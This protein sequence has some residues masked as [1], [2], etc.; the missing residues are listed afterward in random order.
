MT[1]RDFI[2]KWCVYALALLPVW[3]LDAYVLSR[4]PLFGVKPMLLPL[5]AV[6]AAVLEGPASGGA[7]ALGVGFLCYAM[8]SGGPAMLLGL[9]LIGVASGFAA[10]YLLRQNLLGCF[11]CS[12]GSLL[13][14]DACRIVWRLLSGTELAPMLRVAG[15]EIAWSLVFVPLVYAIFRWVY[16]RTQFATLF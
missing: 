13:A 9:T 3:F 7:F 12:L 15:L 5:A 6:A 10:K 4:F 1:R 14:L 11:V 16:N 8:H 2:M